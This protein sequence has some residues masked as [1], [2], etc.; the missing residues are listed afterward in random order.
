MS[1]RGRLSLRLYNRE[2]PALLELAIVFSVRIDRAHDECRN[3]RNCLRARLQSVNSTLWYIFCTSRPRTNFHCFHGEK[4]FRIHARIVTPCCLVRHRIDHLK[5]RNWFRL[6]ISS[7][8]LAPTAFWRPR[9]I[10][11]GVTFFLDRFQRSVRMFQKLNILG[12]HRL[13]V[14]WLLT[15]RE[16]SRS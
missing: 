6:P 10:S 16:E 3:P 8:R 2:T 11:M 1:L 12:L 7:H 15:M 13:L 5:V 14:G 9:K 4:C